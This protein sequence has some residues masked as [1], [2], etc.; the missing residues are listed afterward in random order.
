M[1]RWLEKSDENPDYWSSLNDDTAA[2]AA[3]CGEHVVDDNESDG[4]AD[5]ADTGA[6]EDAV[7]AVADDN[8]DNDDND[9]NGGEAGDDSDEAAALSSFEDFQRIQAQRRSRLL[10]AGLGSL[11]ARG[12]SSD[13]STLPAAPA[14]AATHERPRIIVRSPLISDASMAFVPGASC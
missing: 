10:A 13:A 8:N 7:A 3:P 4:S 6:I 14:V 2:I 11:P 12:V 9:D 5:D 1:S